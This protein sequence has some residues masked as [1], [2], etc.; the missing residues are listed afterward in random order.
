MR[1]HFNYFLFSMPTKHKKTHHET[2]QKVKPIVQEDETVEENPVF[3]PVVVEKIVYRKQRVHGF[4]RTLTILALLVIGFLLLGES[5]GIAKVA[6]GGF[7][8]NTVY[9]LFII[10]STIVIRSYKGIFGKLFGLII[11]LSVFG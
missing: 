8:L 7:A 2:E 4:F 11:F 6:I 9:P 5:M 10:F 3:D 1:S